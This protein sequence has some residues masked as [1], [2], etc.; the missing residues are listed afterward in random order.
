M[1]NR[2]GEGDGECYY[3]IGVED[4]GNALGISKEELEI[5][6]S[7]INTIAINLGCTTKIQKLIEG[8]EGLIAEIHKKTRSD[9]N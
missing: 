6:L 3:Y 8:K 9:F 2:L 4:N 5:S 7:V 1:N